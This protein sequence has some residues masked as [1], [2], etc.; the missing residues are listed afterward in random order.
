M[1]KKMQKM[2]QRREG[3]F[4]SHTQSGKSST[5]EKTFGRERNYTYSLSNNSTITSIQKK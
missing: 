2:C 3:Y 4:K 1:K 5:R